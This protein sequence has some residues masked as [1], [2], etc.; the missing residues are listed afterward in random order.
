MSADQELET[1]RKLA[2]NHRA[3]C[4]RAANKFNGLLLDLIDSVGVEVLDS[5]ECLLAVLSD[6]TSKTEA[7]TETLEPND[8]AAIWKEIELHLV[9]YVDDKGTTLK[10]ALAE[11]GVT[12]PEFPDFEKEDNTKG[13]RP[14]SLFFKI[15]IIENDNEI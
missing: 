7:E 4:Y 14:K 3:K 5:I 12:F 8:L 13:G 2:K 11:F 1:Y 9:S 6:I 10:D 15:D